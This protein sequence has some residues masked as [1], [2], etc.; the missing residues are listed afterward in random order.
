MD[1]HSVW[2]GGWSIYIAIKSL[3]SFLHAQDDEWL[4]QRRLEIGNFGASRSLISGETGTRSGAGFPHRWGVGWVE[5][6]G[7][8][9]DDG[10]ENPARSKRL[11]RQRAGLIQEFALQ[12][13]VHRPLAVLD[14][15]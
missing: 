5:H 12:Q 14:T 6:V 4:R 15:G 9:G 13:G 11:T 7:G 8:V 10:W 3:F 1:G 2:P